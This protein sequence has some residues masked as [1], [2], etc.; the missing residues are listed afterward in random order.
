MIKLYFGP[1]PNARKISIMLEELALPYEVVEVD[2]LAGDQFKPDF[3][4]ISPNNKMPVIVDPEGP[5]GDPIVVWETGAILIYLAEKYKRLIPDEARARMECLKW[6]MFQM[7]G[8]GPMAGQ[9]AFFR[10]YATEKIPLA[11]E[12]YQGELNRQMRVMEQHLASH[13]Y[14]AGDEYS[15]AD[16]AVYPWWETIR[17][18][19]TE[20]RPA[21]ERWG[22]ELAGRAAVAKGMVLLDNR[23]RPEVIQAGMTRK[24][25][26]QTYSNLYGTDQR[27][28]TGRSDESE[29]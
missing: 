14:F 8:V 22:Q 13:A 12:R 24:M 15:I 10:F 29:A 19:S 6:L 1:T 16:I 9:F 2:I 4:A 25:S 21:L 18:I 27:T 3:L 11:I 20:P 23:M 5:D 28:Q 17:L 26:A 7:A